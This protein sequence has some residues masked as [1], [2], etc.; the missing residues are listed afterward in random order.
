[1]AGAPTRPLTSMTRAY[2]ERNRL[3]WNAATVAHNS[4]KSD[5]AGFLRK[6]GTTLFPDEVALLGDVSGCR[7]AHLLCN[8]GQDSLCLARLGADVTGVDI[9]DEAIAFARTLSVDSKIDATFVQSDVYDWLNATTE[10]FD[11]AFA[12]YGALPW[13]PDLTAWAAGLDRVVRPGGRVVL[14]EFHPVAMMFDEDWIHRYPYASSGRVFEERAGVGDYVGRSLGGLSPSGF[15]SGVEDFHNRHPSYEFY[16]S[17][18]DVIRSL[19][20]AGFVPTA[21]R[22]YPYANGCR[23]WKRLR[24]LPGRRYLPPADIPALPMMYGLMARKPV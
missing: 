22:D 23:M 5:Q 6:G 4:H 21:V 7:L 2:R 3:S 13:L 18:A 14:I 1:M 15:L 8:S 9:S 10:R 17:P 24:E 11:I 20:A 12:S 19:I 16:W